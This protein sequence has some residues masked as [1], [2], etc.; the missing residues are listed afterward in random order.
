MLSD[1]YATKDYT[2]PY[3][4]NIILQQKVMTVM[5]NQTDGS[6]YRDFLV[7]PIPFSNCIINK[8]IFY[9]N[10]NEISQFGIQNY[11]CPDSINLTLQGNFY[12]PVHKR[13]ELIF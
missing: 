6:M 3:Y 9:P 8:N 10:A 2:N 12:S 7:T 4:G 5:T 1:F 11:Y 13:V